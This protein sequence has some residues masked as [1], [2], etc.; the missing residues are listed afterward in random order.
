MLQI[1][2]LINSLSV[3]AHSW[4]GILWLEEGIELV[5]Y[6]HPLIETIFLRLLNKLKAGVKAVSSVNKFG[7]EHALQG[8]SE[9]DPF[10]SPLFTSI[11]STQVSWMTSNYQRKTLDKR[12]ILSRTP[13]FVGKRDLWS[14]RR[15]RIV[16]PSLL[17]TASKHY[18]SSTSL[19][20]M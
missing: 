4:H 6:F 10:S 5:V 19:M 3:H 17:T 13:I 15:S 9:L 20:N 14:F 7:L 2:G 11:E 12:Y 8:I 16:L 1:A 18:S